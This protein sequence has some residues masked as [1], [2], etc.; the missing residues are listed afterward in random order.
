MGRKPKNGYSEIDE[1][2][3]S[4]EARNFSIPASEQETVELKCQFCNKAY[5]FRTA[6]YVKKDPPAK[7]D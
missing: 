1:D 6:D 3:I 7:E 2:D 4:I 5:V